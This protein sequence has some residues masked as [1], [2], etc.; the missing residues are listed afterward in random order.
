M[1]PVFSEMNHYTV[2]SRKFGQIGGQYRIG[3]DPASCLSYSCNVVNI[4]I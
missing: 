2:R 1:S 4:Y 3:L